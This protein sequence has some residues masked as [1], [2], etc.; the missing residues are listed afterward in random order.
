MNWTLYA[1]IA[2]ALFIAES[3]YLRLATHY[4]IIDTPNHRSSHNRLTVRGGGVIFW[5]A[6]F[7][8]FIVTDFASPI[9]FA[10]LT[11]VA[12][13]SFL[14]DIYSISNRLRFVVQLVSVCLLLLQTGF[15]QESVW[16]LIPGL[17]VACGVLN[18][19]NFMDG[20]NGI[21]AFYSAVTVATLIVINRFWIP[22]TDPILPVFS[23]ISLL[24][25]SFFNARRQARCFAGD[26]GS[27]SM[28]FLVIYLLVSLMRESR[29]VVYMLLLA[30]YG[31]DSVMTILSRL[32]QG[33]NIFQPHKA[34]LYQLLVHR[35]KLPHLRVAFLYALVQGLINVVVL[36]L[37]R[38]D[39]Q[40]QWLGSGALLAVLVFF[41]WLL[42]N[43]LLNPGQPA[44]NPLSGET[45]PRFFEG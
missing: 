18:A 29:Q 37:V 26:V 39:E 9:F 27:V 2:F 3:L 13:I 34:H 16:W 38:R 42:K 41:Y 40:T 8:A 25:F 12:L 7:F 19:Y 14:D 23:L 5:L 22:F 1:S 45:R 11:L 28:A 21:T 31:I 17:I 30:V 36:E 15:W 20:I 24:V 6:A 10:G 44:A 43:R 32:V 4:Q 33:E 35:L